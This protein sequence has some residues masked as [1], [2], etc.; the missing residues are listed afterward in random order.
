VL[1]LTAAVLGGISLG[2]GKGTVSKALVG[3]LIVLLI[4]NGIT[5]MG[6]PGG[7][8]RMALASILLLSAVIDI[9]WLKNRHRIVKRSM[10]ARP[11]TTCSPPRRLRQTAAHPGR[12]TTSC[13]M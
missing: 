11:I 6:L 4:T 7:I 3:T 13:A 1:V 8:N 5:T 10:S 12:S 9:R 2:G